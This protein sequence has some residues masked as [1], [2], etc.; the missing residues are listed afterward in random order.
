MQ[1]VPIF[2]ISLESRTDRRSYLE[3]NFRNLNHSFSFVNAIYPLDLPSNMQNSAIAVRASHIKALQEFLL[4]NAKYGLILEDDVDVNNKLAFQLFENLNQLTQFFEKS[5]RVIQLGTVDFSSNSMLR[6]TLHDFYSHIFGFFKYQQSDRQRLR[7]EIG[8]VEF[9]EVEKELKRI[10]KVRITPLFGYLIGSQAYLIT[11]ESAEW[12]ISNFNSRKE[13]DL[14]SRFSVDNFLEE[15]SCGPNYAAEIMTMR[16]S[17]QILPQRL[18]PS[19]NNYYPASQTKQ[20]IPHADKI[21][22]SE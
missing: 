21:D 14:N 12:I 3:Q 22:Y 19:D 20:T 17:K 5:F 16:I 15:F 2:V 13:W 1:E 10:F 8:D 7:Q 9:N 4:T 11:R 6:R 18:T